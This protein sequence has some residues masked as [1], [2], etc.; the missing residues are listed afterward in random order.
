M[1]RCS[2]SRV[3]NFRVLRGRERADWMAQRRYTRWFSARQAAWRPCFLLE[4][5]LICLGSLLKFSFTPHSLLHRGA[6]LSLSF[7]ERQ[8]HDP[9]S[10]PPGSSHV[11]SLTW[12]GL[13]QSL[14][15]VPADKRVTS[16][17][18]PRKC[19]DVTLR[20][21]PASLHRRLTAASMTVSGYESECLTSVRNLFPSSGAHLLTGHW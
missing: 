6:R 1:N 17:S 21:R 9:P 2:T 16:L 13:L 4:V 5:W 19:E 15:E 7:A 10:A 12:A 20:R 18:W 3:S 8:H 11:L 14:P